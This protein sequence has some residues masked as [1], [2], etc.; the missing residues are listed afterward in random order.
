[1]STILTTLPIIN[2]VTPTPNLPST[3]NFS[4]L[5]EGELTY[6]NQNKESY[7]NIHVTS[8]TQHYE[9]ILSSTDNPSE[10]SPTC[11]VPDSWLPDPTDCHHFYVCHFLNDIISKPRRIAC[12]ANRPVFS[13]EE[14]RCLAKAPCIVTCQTPATIATTELMN[15]DCNPK[16]L[17]PYSSVPDPSDCTRYFICIFLYDLTLEP[18]RAKCP[19]TKPFF[20]P[21][22]KKCEKWARCITGCSR[23]TVFPAISTEPPIT[24]SSSIE[25]NCLPQCRIPD[26]LVHDPKD[27]QAYYIC[28]LTKSGSLKPIKMQCPEHK[29][30][31]DKMT[32]SC[33]A[34]ADCNT[35]CSDT[36]SSNL[37]A[38][39]NS[40]TES[41]LVLTDIQDDTHK[42]TLSFSNDSSEVPEMEDITGT[43]PQTS[44]NESISLNTEDCEPICESHNSITYDPLDCHYYYVCMFTGGKKY[45]SK[46]KCPLERPIFHVD[47]KSCQGNVPCIQI[48]NKIITSQLDLTEASHNISATSSDIINPTAHDLTTTI[49]HSPL[50][51]EETLVPPA[52]LSTT[53]Q[54]V[55]EILSTN[56]YFTE[57]F[58]DIADYT[59]DPKTVASVNENNSTTLN[60]LT[61]HPLEI[62]SASSSVT[63]LTNFQETSSDF[64]SIPHPSEIKCSQECRKQ[65]IL[66]P[67]LT[68]C[69]YYYVCIHLNGLIPQPV[70]SK[71][72]LH[73]PIF[74]TGT[75]QCVADGVCHNPCSNSSFIQDESSKETTPAVSPTVTPDPCLPSCQTLNSVIPDPSD[76]HFYYYCTLSN[77]MLTP[78]RMKCPTGRP[79]FNINYLTCSSNIPCVASCKKLQPHIPNP[80]SQIIS[81][82]SSITYC[83]YA[84]YFASSERCISS[85]D[86][87]Y[88][89]GDKI[90]KTR[91]QCPKGLVFNPISTYPYCVS[92]HDCPYDPQKY[93]PTANATY[94]RH[95]GRFPKCRDCCSDF[96]QCQPAPQDTYRPVIVQC[97]GGLVFNTDPIYPVCLRKADCP[98]GS[99]IIR[100]CEVQGNYPSCPLGNCCRNYNHCT[101][102]GRLQ[103]RTCPYPFVFNNHPSYPY[104][105]L[106][107][108]CPYISLL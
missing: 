94:C 22:S 73:S 18:V 59:E 21:V 98:T 42:T 95:P 4:A 103:Q 23:P 51:I 55:G 108:N 67:D 34:E 1:M 19:R 20:D 15:T 26:T 63:P 54:S 99:Q 88:H 46:V 60:D 82:T 104:C 89:Q 107:W 58:S 29:I 93:G 48:C 11:L 53:V 100:E 3:S 41:L 47:T 33:T 97:S 28:T 62:T 52:L 6:N 8:T 80:S 106:A 32:G 2:S 76:C 16:C 38:L 5:D 50:G 105:I 24:F 45:V 101:H 64:T 27:C 90:L 56:V 68:D 75:S 44:T 66:L 102:D 61:A 7:Q 96:I 86:Y 77:G 92:P 78:V 84:G 74:D 65:G 91:K 83:P 13:R 43:T 49:L 14:G 70:R 10:C 87:C 31:F 35:D 30:I 79:I 17:V 12:P 81:L 71:C 40:Q 72:P 57:N 9:T 39:D 25:D 36:S 69:R 85:Y 37:T